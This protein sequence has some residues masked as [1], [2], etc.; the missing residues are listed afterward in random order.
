MNANPFFYLSS[1]TMVEEGKRGDG[2]TLKPFVTP[3]ASAP[4]TGSG[5]STMYLYIKTGPRSSD[6]FE[7]FPDRPLYVGREKVRQ[8]IL[9]SYPNARFYSPRDTSIQALLTSRQAHC[10]F[11][12]IRKD[13]SRVDESG[14]FIRII[15]K[16]DGS[17]PTNDLRILKRSH[18]GH[19]KPHWVKITFTPTPIRLREHQRYCIG[20][21]FHFEVGDIHQQLTDDAYFSGQ[22]SG[23]FGPHYP[24]RPARL[25]RWLDCRLFLPRLT[26]SLYRG[27]L[28]KIPSLFHTSCC[29]T[30]PHYGGGLLLLDHENLVPVTA[31]TRDTAPKD[32]SLGVCLISRPRLGPDGRSAFEM[33]H[34]WDAPSDAVIFCHDVIKILLQLSKGFQYLRKRCWVHGSISGEA[35]LITPT[36]R[37]FFAQITNFSQARPG[38]PP[39]QSGEPSDEFLPGG[40]G[41]YADDIY[42]FGVLMVNFFLSY[43]R[44]PEEREGAHERIRKDL[45]RNKLDPMPLLHDDVAK[46]I[47]EL[48]FP[49][50]MLVQWC[51]YSEKKDRPSFDILRAE[52]RRWT[53]Y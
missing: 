38:R 41:S 30:L 17:A 33:V 9:S 39:G 32:A 37:S 52:L 28:M 1:S 49:L 5:V 13:D 2:I 46:V 19:T 6:E 25:V 42:H 53:H 45:E 48:R 16:K 8:L 34:K 44:A 35:V 20:G 23:P 29:E 15:P 7:I 3:V 31:M 27:H 21:Q 36:P 4:T 10:V 40:F 11:E 12:Y 24:G 51:M 22:M 43:R 47:T 50:P 14:F 26:P 18:D